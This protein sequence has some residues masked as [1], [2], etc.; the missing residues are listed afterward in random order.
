MRTSGEFIALHSLAPQ[1][2]SLICY[3]TWKSKECC[4][5]MPEVWLVPCNSA[6]SAADGT[7]QHFSSRQIV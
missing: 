5:F 3:D 7:S 4:Q 1:L 2:F 6:S